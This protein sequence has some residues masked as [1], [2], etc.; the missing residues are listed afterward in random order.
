MK[1]HSYAKY[2]QRGSLD[3]AFGILSIGFCLLAFVVNTTVQQF[4]STNNLDSLS[5]IQS[6]GSVVLVLLDQDGNPQDV[7]PQLQAIRSNSGGDNNLCVIYFN[8]GVAINY[9][10]PSC[11]AFVT[12]SMQEAASRSWVETLVSFDINSPQIYSLNLVSGP[13]SATTTRD[14]VTPIGYVNCLKVAG[15]FT[16]CETSSGALNNFG[17]SANA[18]QQGEST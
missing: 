8:E 9:S 5:G 3:S 12:T 6:Q 7:S 10:D 16:A 15:R 17:E 11:A 4:S 18:V 14:P 1:F 2:L 13:T